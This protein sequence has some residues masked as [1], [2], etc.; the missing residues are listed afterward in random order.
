MFFPGQIVTDGALLGVI[1][2]FSPQDK[3]VVFWEDGTR[4]EVPLSQLHK[5][6]AP[7]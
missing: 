4:S 2:K 6:A 5:V 1:L 7:D 3:A